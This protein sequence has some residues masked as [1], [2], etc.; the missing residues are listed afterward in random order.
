ML[1]MKSEKSWAIMKNTTEHFGKM[2]RRDPV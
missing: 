2:P 1:E